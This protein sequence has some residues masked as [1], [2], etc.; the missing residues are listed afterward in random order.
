M[1]MTRWHKQ[2]TDTPSYLHF[3]IGQGVNTVAKLCAATGKT[4]D[5]IRHHLRYLLNRG[6]ILKRKQKGVRGYVYA[7]APFGKA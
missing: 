4:D 5:T 1:A 3:Y 2:R 6:L 7:Q